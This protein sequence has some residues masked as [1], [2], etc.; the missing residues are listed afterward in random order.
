MN[1]LSTRLPYLALLLA[2]SL[3]AC[4]TLRDHDSEGCSVDMKIR[5]N[6]QDLID[7]RADL[8]AP[9]SIHVQA[10]DRVVYLTGLVDTSVDKRI[11]ESVAAHTPGVAR[12]VNSIEQN[13]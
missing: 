9:H 4:A 13:N 8:G 12:V 6:V 1:P 2:S 7:E 10:I 5:T 11:A 3:S